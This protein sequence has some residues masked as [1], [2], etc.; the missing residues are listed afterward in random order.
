MIYAREGA[1]NLMDRSF[2]DFPHQIRVE[3]DG[4]EI[5]VLEVV[6]KFNL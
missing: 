6:H 5:E 2:A 1:K 4:V 3:V